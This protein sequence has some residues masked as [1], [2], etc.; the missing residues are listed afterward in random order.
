MGTIRLVSGELRGRSIH[1]PAGETTRPLLSRLRKS[2]ADILRTRLRGSTILDLFGGSG[3]IAFELL[4]NG[5]ASAE[6]VE[7]HAP[8]AGI[9]RRNA[10]SLH[11]QG[12]VQ[13]HCGNAIQIIDVLEKNN[14]CFDI[15]IVAPPYGR[16]L[17]QEALKALASANVV[18]KEGLIVVQRDNREPATEAAGPLR[19]TR[20]RTYGRTVFEFFEPVAG[21]PS[22]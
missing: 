8:A 12:R 13:V 5:A 1:T 16:G 21:Q 19:H 2:L 11:L 10:E 3:A 22:A 20:T 6:I 18:K 4:S 7:L 15:V 9:V 14:R 17:Q